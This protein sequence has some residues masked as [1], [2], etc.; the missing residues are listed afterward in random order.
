MWRWSSAHGSSTALKMSSWMSWMEC[1]R[2]SKVRQG[3][4]NSSF[5]VEYLL[6][7][8]HLFKSLRI[9]CMK[10]STLI[11]SHPYFA[12]PVGFQRICSEYH[13]SGF[14]DTLTCQIGGR[15]GEPQRGSLV[16]SSS[17]KR[18]TAL[19]IFQLWEL[20][21]YYTLGSIEI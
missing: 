1:S 18:V 9:P 10:G 5:S 7:Q 4:A 3:I 20:Y 13:L 8:T 12:L 15:V 21:V 11:S 17:Q 2:D 19:A 6:T 16:G 14:W